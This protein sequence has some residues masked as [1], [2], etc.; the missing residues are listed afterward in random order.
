MDIFNG[1]AGQSWNL[2]DKVCFKNLTVYYCPYYGI[3]KLNNVCVTVLCKNGN[4]KN[5][6]LDNDVFF[7]SMNE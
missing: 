1:F 7:S 4:S 3:K 2:L 6:K 5:S